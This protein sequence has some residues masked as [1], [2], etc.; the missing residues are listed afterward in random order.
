M[1]VKN[2]LKSFE[3]AAKLETAR[4]FSLI[5]GVRVPS[6]TLVSSKAS[7]SLLEILA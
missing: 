7:K 5:A 4:T 6:A 1:Q 2:P 3:L